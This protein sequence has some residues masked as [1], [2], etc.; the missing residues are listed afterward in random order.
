MKKS[1]TLHNSVY[2]KYPSRVA[3][4][5]ESRLVIARDKDVRKGGCEEGTGNIFG[6]EKIFENWAMGKVTWVWGRVCTLA[7]WPEPGPWIPHE[8]RRELTPHC[9]LLVSAPRACCP[10]TCIKY[11]QSHN[12]DQF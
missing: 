9:C 3:I 11:T 2:T 1:H 6:G 12:G 5:I 8:G 10:H 7:W 4:M